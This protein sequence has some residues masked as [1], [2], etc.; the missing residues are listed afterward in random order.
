MK[1]I[2]GIWR[3]LQ[4]DSRIIWVEYGVLALA[5]IAP[6]LLPGYI[7]TL[8][9][10]FTPHF[11]WPAELT[12][13]YLIEALLWLLHIVL[14]G[15][16]IEKLIL[17]LILVL[18]GVGMHRIILRFGPLKN[19]P[20]AIWRWAAY[21][22]GVFYMINPFIYSRFMAGQWMVLMGYALLP[23]FVS[24]LL[25]LLAKPCVGQAIK[26][27]L[28]TAGIMMISLHHAG[29]LMILE[30]T[31]IGVGLWRYRGMMQKQLAK[32]ATFGI[33][34]SL[35]VSSFWW[36]PT[37][38]RLNGVGRAI[39][40]FNQADVVAFA[41]G[42]GSMGAIGDV[43][44]LQGFWVEAQKLFVMPQSVMPLWG[45]IVVVLWVLVIIGA[46]QAWRYHRLAFAI[47]GVSLL[48]G[49]ILAAT[50]TISWLA[51]IAPIFSA[52]REPH[53]FV[54]LVVLGYAILGAF[55]LAYVAAWVEKRK[56]EVASQVA[57]FACLLL[58]IIITP[59][60]FWGFAGQLFPR[61]YPSEW[62]ALNNTLSEKTLFL[63]WHQYMKY[64]F[65][66]RI[67]ASPIEKFF[68]APIIASD[69]PE[70]RGVSPTIPN[71]EKQEV[72]E[73]LRSPKS[74]L[75]VL[76]KYN[77]KRIVVLKE[78]DY[79]KYDYLNRLADIRQIDQNDRL[80]VYEVKEG[81]R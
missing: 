26:T 16:V 2:G 48:V 51:G 1:M 28:W 47:T 21:F 31:I 76:Q 30:A 65:S 13:A 80:K 20:P 69:D 38:L 22:A 64:E 19:V 67:I 29:T 50:P 35:V 77:I 17:L 62:Y 55:G 68:A 60:M 39:V 63:P 74:L 81:Q 27:A 32:Y 9:L 59:T 41:T 25:K 14:P 66:G 73:A 18:S 37:V 6:L 75:G 36:I 23:F 34:V 4:N 5:I 15:D 46:V 57:I 56:G 40:D 54:N 42:G 3:W 72:G 61:Q 12:N 24:S 7:L 45:I 43:I 52:Y 49:I 10:V 44:R 33:I 11:S 79:K 58:P 53:K 70:F 8:D 78:D 71:A